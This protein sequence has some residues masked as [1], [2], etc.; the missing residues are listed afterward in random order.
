MEREAISSTVIRVI[1]ETF[2]YPAERITNQTIADDVDGWDSLK[3]TILMIRLQKAL[4][5]Q[6]PETV[7]AEATSVGDL[8]ARLQEL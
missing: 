1:S 7:A 6:I 2:N 8:I 4:G 5:I 3:H